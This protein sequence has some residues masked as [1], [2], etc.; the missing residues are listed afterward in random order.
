MNIQIITNMTSR[1]VISMSTLVS[2]GYKPG[3]HYIGMLNHMH[4][5]CANCN[6]YTNHELMA[7][8]TYEYRYV[9]KKCNCCVE[10]V[11]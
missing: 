9:C 4:L 10:Y 5:F 3:P 6:I 7:R 11:G 8:N 1:L 2:N